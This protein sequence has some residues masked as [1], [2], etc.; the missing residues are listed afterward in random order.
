MKKLYY[1]GMLVF[2]TTYAGLGISNHRYG[3]AGFMI[4]F[5]IWWALDLFNAYKEN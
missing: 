3:L 2:S 5:A 1:G 4:G